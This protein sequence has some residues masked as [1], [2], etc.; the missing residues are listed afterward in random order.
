MVAKTTKH[1]KIGFLKKK[2]KKRLKFTN[3]KQ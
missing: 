3:R 2:K 1:V